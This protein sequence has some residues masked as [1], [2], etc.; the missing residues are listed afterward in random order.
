MW[1]K[2]LEPLLFSISNHSLFFGKFSYLTDIKANKSRL[3]FYG[4]VFEEP[5]RLKIREGT[6]VYEYK[7]QY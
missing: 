6:A 3:L 2:R 4:L 1:G 7:S 5:Y